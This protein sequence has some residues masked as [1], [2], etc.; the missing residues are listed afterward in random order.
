MCAGM[1]QNFDGLPPVDPESGLINVV[2]DTPR[3]NRCKYRYAEKLG[4][5]R[6]GKLLPLGTSF[7]YDFGF[8][9]STAG[10]TAT[11]LMCS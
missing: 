10:G 5:F 1:N 3:G 4:L 9:P 6:L 8:I 2:I 7:P 11:H